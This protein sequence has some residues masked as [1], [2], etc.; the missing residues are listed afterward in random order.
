M[1]CGVAFVFVGCAV[2]G[3]SVSA[4]S[5]RNAE[6]APAAETSPPA[7]MTSSEPSPPLATEPATPASTTKTPAPLVPAVR[8]NRERPKT[9]R[10]CKACNGSWGVHG[11]SQQPACNCRTSD[12]GKRCR[13]GIE[14]ESLCTAGENPEREVT[15]RGSPERGFWIGKCSEFVDVFGCF[16]PIEDGAGAK[17]VEL[18]EPPQMICAD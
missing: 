3:S 14:C 8:R 9:E 12:G 2:Q 18:G 4:D 1:L 15:E 5:V 7:P 13:D 11:L 16:R 17:P 6:T 10:E